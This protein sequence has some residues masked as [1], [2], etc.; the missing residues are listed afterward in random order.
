MAS[1]NQDFVTY[2][3]D[4]VSPIFTVTTTAN[5]VVDISAVTE[6]TW[7][8]S[9]SAES[10]ALITKK[11]SLG[12]ISFVN[13]GTDGKFQVAITSANTTLLAAAGNYFVHLAS[14]TDA[15]GNVTTVAVGRMQVGS[16]PMWTYDPSQ[17]G[18]VDLHTVRDLIGDV[19]QGDQLLF[20]AEIT[21][22]VSSYSNLYLAA[23][24][25]ARK[26]AGR[27]ARDVDTQQGELRTMYSSRR[28]AYQS[29][30]VDLEN[31]GFARVTGTGYAG[32]I[33]VTD[34]D[35]QVQDTDRVQPQFNIA[36]MDDLLPQ[37]VVG[38]ETPGS[39]TP[40]DSNVP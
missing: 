23:A 28:R 37:G 21:T 9:A 34:K 18:T 29:I 7:S 24:E 5:V 15:G 40:F 39:V 1:L 33:S 16:P 31:R 3:G 2:S 26:I 11:K 27:F 6:I 13:T 38:H 32:G 12:E 4:T 8:V 25:C 36:M 10:T 19:K 14:I 35:T 20:D 17:V 30:A 22:A